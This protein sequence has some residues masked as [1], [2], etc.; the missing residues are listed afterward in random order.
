MRPGRLTQEKKPPA[1]IAPTGGSVF[2][3]CRGRAG[4]ATPPSAPPCRGSHPRGRHHHADLLLGRVDEG[5]A[6]RAHRLRFHADDALLD[7]VVHPH[8]LA[9]LHGDL[10][11]ELPLEGFP[12]PRR[13]RQR[14]G[15]R[16]RPHPTPHPPCPHPISPDLSG[17][18]SHEPTTG[19]VTRRQ[20]SLCV[21][22]QRFRK[23]WLPLP[24]ASAPAGGYAGND[25]NNLPRDTKPAGGGPPPYP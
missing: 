13:A 19:I 17:P 23:S 24:R 22:P 10:V 16:G 20:N 15:H 4:K 5:I 1:G 7:H 8:G 9:L 2:G 14:H 12:G 6:F 11:A 3:M 18:D 21:T 25:P